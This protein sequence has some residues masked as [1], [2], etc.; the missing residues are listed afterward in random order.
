MKNDHERFSDP[1]F[2]YG[3]LYGKKMK[4]NA[5]P[6]RC[7]WR[8]SGGMGWHSRQCSRKAVVD[9]LWCKQHSPASAQ[10][11]EKERQERWA[12]ERYNSAME[13]WRRR[14]EE[15]A[16]TAIK[17]IAKGEMNDPAGYA[18]MLLDEWSESEPKKP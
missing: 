16:L 8:V 18:Q 5:D 13:W 11:R 10:D 3:G 2:Y 1:D 12:L 9:G 15:T 17:E 14:C 6:E 4:G 7:R